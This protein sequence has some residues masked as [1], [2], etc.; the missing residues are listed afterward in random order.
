MEKEKS[1]KEESAVTKFV[2]VLSM[3]FLI[4]VPLTFL[5]GIYFFGM[6]GLFNVLGIQYESLWSLF[7]FALLYFV[8]DSFADVVKIAFV[9]LLNQLSIASFWT[10]LTTNFLVIWALLSLM[11]LLMDSITMSINTQLIAAAIIAV[12]E[13]ALNKISRKEEQTE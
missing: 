3:T 13:V 9:Q 2:I 12:I 10:V 7:W 4:A 1:F 8:L 6:S 5:F 11:N